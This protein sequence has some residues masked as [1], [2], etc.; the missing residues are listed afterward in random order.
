MHLYE[1]RYTR[2]SGRLRGNTLPADKRTNENTP[3]RVRALATFIFISR[4]L[5]G[6]KLGS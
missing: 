5:A 2:F 3:P 4:E 1:I 6:R